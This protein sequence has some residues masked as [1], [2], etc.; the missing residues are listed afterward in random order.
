[1]RLWR[2]NRVSVSSSLPIALL[3]STMFSQSFDG[4]N[5]N[6]SADITIW[7]RLDETWEVQKTKVKENSIFYFEWNCKYFITVSNFCLSNGRR[8]E[9]STPT[10]NR[11]RQNI[12]K[13]NASMWLNERK[14]NKL[15]PA[16]KRQSKI[17][18]N[19]YSDILFLILNGNS[20]RHWNNVSERLNYIRLFLNCLCSRALCSSR[21]AVSV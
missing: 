5:E 11:R 2:D 4:I 16:N 21:I 14:P 12:F 10:T 8:W 17:H 7:K 19:D 1:M 18:P 3:L 15:T 6:V 13:A 20:N 9:A